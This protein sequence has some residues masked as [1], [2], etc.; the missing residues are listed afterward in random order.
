MGTHYGCID[1]KNTYKR[2]SEK[3]FLSYG[4]IDSQSVKTILTSKEREIDGAGNFD[5][6]TSMLFWVRFQHMFV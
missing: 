4:I 1:K 2:R 6:Y 3:N 5:M